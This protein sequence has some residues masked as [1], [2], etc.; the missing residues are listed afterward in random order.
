MVG[1]SGGTHY[2]RHIKTSQSSAAQGDE[3]G[4]SKGVVR[5]ISQIGGQRA[6]GHSGSGAVHTILYSTLVGCLVR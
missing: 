5:H 1:K 3:R 2:L 6:V 4:V